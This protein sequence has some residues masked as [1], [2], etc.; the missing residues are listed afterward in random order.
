MTRSSAGHRTVPHTADMRIEAWAPSLEQCVA[1]AAT[2]MV[3]G[4]ADLSDAGPSTVRE[5]RTE[6]PDPEDLLVAVL[7]E[8]IYRM[9]AHGELPTS[10]TMHGPRVSF[11]MADTSQAVTIGAVPKA[12]SL[13]DLHIARGAEGWHCAVTL[14]V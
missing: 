2:A 7:D 5:F 12:V 9:D 4:F 10:V 13:N 1:E 3:E 11:T 14:D 6:S 8:I